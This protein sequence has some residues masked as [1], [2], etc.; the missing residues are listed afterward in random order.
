MYECPKACE[1]KLSE[2]IC[3]ENKF[4]NESCSCIEIEQDNC[5]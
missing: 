1:C 3:G 5:S 4:D 2:K